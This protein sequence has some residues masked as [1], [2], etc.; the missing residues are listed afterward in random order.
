VFREE[1]EIIRVESDREIRTRF[2]LGTNSPTDATEGDADQT[3]L[4]A[5]L[6]GSPRGDSPCLN[7]IRSDTPT[8]IQFDL[9]IFLFGTM[10]TVAL[11]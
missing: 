9:Y 10:G 6:T 8:D 2:L 5:W 4:K 3:L 1:G 11:S 7:R